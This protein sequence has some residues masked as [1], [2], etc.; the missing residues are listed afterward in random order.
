MALGAPPTR[1]VRLVLARTTRLVA[2]GVV[3]GA[4][5][6]WWAS[7]FVAT[8]IYGLEPRDLLTIAGS[9]AILATVAVLAA[10][11]P[12]RSA[13]RTDPAIVLREG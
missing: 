7:R 9:I 5:I 11:W 12:A 8:L 1:V 10:W 2:V 3:A 4:G 13:V 6:S